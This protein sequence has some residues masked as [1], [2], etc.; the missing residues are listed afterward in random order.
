MDLLK[1]RRLELLQ[2]FEMV[3]NSDDLSVFMTQQSTV[4]LQE[5]INWMEETVKQFKR[6]QFMRA[7]VIEN[8]LSKIKTSKLKLITI[9]LEDSKFDYNK[10]LTAL[11]HM[12]TLK[13]VGKMRYEFEQ[14]SELP[15]VFKHFHIHIILETKKY[16]SQIIRETFMQFR[17]F[18]KYQN[19]VDVRSIISDNGVDSYL[20]E[21][22]TDPDKFAKQQVDKIWR[23]TLI[24]TRHIPRLIKSVSHILKF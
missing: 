16:K 22:K 10:L 11:D 2:L 5:E 24:D 17:D 6:N 3:H 12:A 21:D 20:F 13:W 4:D 8:N 15:S 19:F 14:G 23:L 9:S 1:K 7:L 18:V